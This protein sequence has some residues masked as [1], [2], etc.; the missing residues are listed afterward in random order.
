MPFELVMLLGFFGAVLLS[1]LPQGAEEKTGES[2]RGRRLQR[3][4]DEAHGDGR[5]RTGRLTGRDEASRRRNAVR[6]AA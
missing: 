3:R 1:L 2:F 4:C 5:G 6:A